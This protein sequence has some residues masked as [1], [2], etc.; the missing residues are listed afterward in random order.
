MGLTSETVELLC[1][2]TIDKIN[3][4]IYYN[5]NSIDYFIGARKG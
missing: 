5:V 1:V 3:S 2:Y 4:T